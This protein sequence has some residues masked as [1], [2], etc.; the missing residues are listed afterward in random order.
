LQEKAVLRRS[1]IASM[2]DVTGK[3]N[4]GRLIEEPEQQAAIRRQMKEMCS[5][6]ESLRVIAAAMHANFESRA[7][8][9]CRCRSIGEQRFGSTDRE[10][11][12]SVWARC[13]A[14][15]NALT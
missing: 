10:W 9:L 4:G 7:S 11:T 2:Y 5:A 15:A 6:G 12:S 13:R 14:P 1:A 8:L 3:R